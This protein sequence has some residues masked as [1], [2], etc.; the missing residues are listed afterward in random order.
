[1]ATITTD[2]YLDG[3]TARTA[4]ETWTINNGAKLTIRTDTRW[5]AN[6]P[7]SM[8]GSLGTVT[9]ASTVTCTLEID[10]T[11]VRWMPYFNGSGF[12]PAIGTTITQGGVSGY[13]LSVHQD[14][15]AAPTAVGAAMPSSGYI[16]FREVTGG[17]FVAGELSG[18]GANATASDRVGFIDVAFDN[19]ASITMGSVGKLIMNGDWFY[20][21]TQTSG[22]A[23]Q[24]IQL[25][26]CGTGNTGNFYYAVQIET[27]PG[28]NVFR[29]WHGLVNPSSSG[30]SMY[31]TNIVGTDSRNTY[32]K[33]IADG[34]IQLGGDGTNLIGYVPPAGCRIRIPNVR[35]SSVATGSRATNAYPLALASAGSAVTISDNTKEVTINYTYLSALTNLFA[36]VGKF[37]ANN[38][39][40][41]SGTGRLQNVRE[42]AVIDGCSYSALSASN[43]QTSPAPN[44]VQCN[45]SV[46]NTSAPVTATNLRVTDCRGI[47]SG[48]NSGASASSNLYFDNIDYTMLTTW[49]SEQAG[50]KF[51]VVS[52]STF[53]NI[54]HAGG[55]IDFSFCKNVTVN[56][57]DY[58][59]R[60]KGPLTAAL[61]S[62][63]QFIQL[64]YPNNV[65]INGVTHGRKGA[66]ADLQPYGTYFNISGT[67]GPLIIRNAGTRSAPLAAGSNSTYH[68]SSIVTMSAG[69]TYIKLQRLYVGNIRGAN[70]IVYSADASSANNIIENVM[71][72][73]FTK[74]QYVTAKENTFKGLSGAADDTAGS[75]VGTHFADFFISDT[76]GSLVWY[77]NTPSLSTTGENY[78]VSPDSSSKYIS[79]ASQV[80]LNSNTDYVYSE[81]TYFVKGH[82]SFRNSAPVITGTNTNLVTYE[83]Q[84][85][86]GSGWNGTWKT[87]NTSNLTA[88]SISPTGFKMKFRFTKSSAGTA[89]IT[90]VQVLT[91]TTAQAQ[92]DNLYTL[93]TAT[94]G[95]TGLI[96]GSEVRVY[97]GT[98]PATSVEI[99]GTEAT[100]GST[101]SISQSVAG[102]NGYIV[103][104][105]MGYQPIYLPYTFK[106]VDDSILIQPVIDRNYN[107][108]V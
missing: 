72:T 24:I 87:L 19:N 9:G 50:M 84:L 53:N 79:A 26:V 106:S 68:A 12:V 75:Y 23:H 49:V 44:S 80:L 51:S 78:I 61:S 8:T 101:F 60:V 39:A 107:N 98:D 91:N 43:S 38:S 36:G 65:K 25:P 34:T 99:G 67:L 81:M 96:P 52:D 16:K 10:G 29:W 6:A 103:I 1:M 57:I 88:E 30:D 56:D 85:D 42:S 7:A 13:L 54:Y 37:V 5:H 73:N 35:I 14:Y 55:E 4:G 40:F 27:G 95:F 74:S 93:D 63:N 66:F 48:G 69:S 100:G 71:C 83:Y 77:G 46:F 89:Q 22:S 59:V 28:T 105:A 90:S 21:D 86:T 2:T 102:Q 92:A 108:P 64:T 18:I 31:S 94:L 47:S 11:K 76:T 97:V 82:T 32:Y 45:F 70:P 3:G 17:Q 33:C 15:I 104:L 62:H 58:C 20:L 41:Y